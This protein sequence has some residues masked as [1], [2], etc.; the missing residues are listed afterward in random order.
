MG[1][2]IY[3]GSKV[4]LKFWKGLDKNIKPENGSEQKIR[5]V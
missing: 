1:W 2:T 4:C 5:F 3:L